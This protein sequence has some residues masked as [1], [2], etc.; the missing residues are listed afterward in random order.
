MISSF[1][2]FKTLK[3]LKSQKNVLSKKTKTKIEK[4]ST[5]PESILHNDLQLSPSNS[6]R[7]V[8]TAEEIRKEI[9]LLLE[10]TTFELFSEPTLTAQNLD[11]FNQY[12]SGGKGI[13]VNEKHI[14]FRSRNQQKNGH[15]M[16]SFTCFSPIQ[17]AFSILFANRKKKK[18]EVDLDDFSSISTD[19][20]KPDKVRFCLF[21]DLFPF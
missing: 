3:S 5:D 1:P 10:E 12:H 19:S 18:F 9:D 8:Q 14:K 6:L 16:A 17:T 4:Y 15:H 7:S 13:S 11:Q 2:S 20:D 21:F